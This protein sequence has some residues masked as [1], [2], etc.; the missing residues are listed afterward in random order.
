MATTLEKLRERK[1][2]LY[3][4]ETEETSIPQVT[5]DR[6]T[7][8]LQSLRERKELGAY[9]QFTTEAVTPSDAPSLGEIGKGLAAEIAVAEGLK[10][11]GATAGALGGPVGVA[12]GYITGAVVGGVT[13][14]LAA[15][16][17][18]GRDSYSWGRVLGDTMLNLIPGFKPVKAGTKLLPKI[19]QR[20]AVGAGV[21]GV[22]AGAEQYVDEGKVTMDRI[23]PALAVGGVF[24]V[25]LGAAGDAWRKNY[26]SKLQGKSPE[27]IDALYRKGDP[28]TVTVIDAITGGDPKGEGKRFVD[29]INSYVIPTKVI[30]RGSKEAIAEAKSKARAATSLAAGVRKSIDDIYRGATAD[31]QN[32][33]DAFIV[34]KRDSLDDESLVGAEIILRDA[35]DKIGE[36]QDTVIDLYDNGL[37]DDMDELLIDKIKRSRAEGSYLRTEYKFFEDMDYTPTEEQRSKAFQSLLREGMKEDEAI[38]FFNKLDRSRRQDNPLKRLNEADQYI[39]SSTNLL[40]KKDELPQEVKDYLGIYTSPGD[41]LYGTISSLGKFAAAEAGN[42]KLVDSLIDSGLAATTR[43][44]MTPQGFVQLSV[45]GDKPI[46]RNGQNYFISEPVRASINR[47]LRSNARE[48]SNIFVENI[49]TDLL[50]TST[51]LAKFVR[52][53]LSLGAYPVA[54]VS[55][56][57]DVVGLGM[58][59]FG[60]FTAKNLRDKKNVFSKMG[61]AISDLNSKG[62]KEGKVDLKRLTRLKELELIDKGVIGSDIREGFN[63]GIAGDFIKSTQITDKVGK[64]YNTFDTAQRLVVFD[65]YTNMLKKYSTNSSDISDDIIEEV[66]AQLTNQTYQNYDKISPIFRYLS[67]I[68]FLNEFGAFLYEQTRTKYNQGKVIR[69]M[70][71]GSFVDQIEKATRRNGKPGLQMEK[72]SVAALGRKRLV[73]LLG[74]AAAASAVVTQFNRLG[75]VTEEEE[76]AVRE[77]GPEWDENAAL[78]IRKDGDKYRVANISYQMPIAEFT[79]V[80]QAGLR[81]ENIKDGITNTLDAL[82]DKFGGDLAINHKQLISTLRNIDLETGKPISTSPKFITKAL[83]LA[84]HYGSETFTPTFIRSDIDRIF[85]QGKFKEEDPNDTLI[86]YT[87]GLRQRIME[88]EKDVRFR[89]KPLQRNIQTLRSRYAGEMLT[90]DIDAAE[91]YAKANRDYRDNVQVYIDKANALRDLGMKEEKIENIIS[92]YARNKQM[93]GDIMT[94][95]ISDMPIA[96]GISGNRRERLQKYIEIAK[97]LPNNLLNKMIQ[98]EFEAGK[99]KRNDVI[100]IQNAVRFR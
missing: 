59:P 29:M 99:I 66:A 6:E 48:K 13:G 3:G 37:L 85:R 47:L 11:A 26:Q 16:R 81:G 22:A 87:I 21:S 52:V 33:I 32:K 92:F 10:Y 65:H 45:K 40:K 4:T 18:E 90:G 50:S 38:D 76:K 80:F 69:S 5:E 97:Q 43:D 100:A 56:A 8:L 98:Q 58:N 44:N 61:I 94:G 95:E 30:G 49:L 93:L 82:W 7:S 39:K 1:R 72:S 86:R 84:S 73:S 79:S 83:D 25:G 71:D 36:Y 20:A 89:L 91:S 24:N 14:S 55:A 28:E 17:L 68:G 63:K 88:P 74:Y 34:G 19:A 78:L 46:S 27:E 41:R 2:L 53:P 23:V 77:A 51:A 57:M 62:I 35:R 15:Q 96:V 42:M 9:K 60:A 70:L 67:R 31:Q 75:G 64:A 12:V 54:L